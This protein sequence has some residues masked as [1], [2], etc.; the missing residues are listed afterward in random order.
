MTDYCLLLRVAAELELDDA[1]HFGFGRGLAGPDFEA[2]GSA[3]PKTAVV[4]WVSVELVDG[5]W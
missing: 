4:D 3:W 1:E 5:G 2:P